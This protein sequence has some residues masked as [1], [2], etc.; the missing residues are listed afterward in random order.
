MKRLLACLV[1]VAPVAMVTAIAPVSQARR[2]PTCTRGLTTVERDPRGLLPLTS[3]SIGPA[4]RA[5]LRYT[6]PAARPLVTSAD[7][8]TVDHERGGEAR[9]ECGTRVWRR[10]VVVYLTL[11][12][13][14]PRSASLSENVFFVGRFRGGYRVWQVVH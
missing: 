2:S 1:A 12:A 10:T 4:A 5:A 6:R 9:A 8:A 7:L 13:F 11:R 3:N 14:E